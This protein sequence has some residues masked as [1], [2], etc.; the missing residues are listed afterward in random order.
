MEELVAAVQEGD[1]ALLH[2]LIALASP[3]LLDSDHCSLL[4]WAAINNRI[5]IA[6]LLIDRGAE[7]LPGGILYET[8][9][10]WALRKKYYAM[11]HL[12]VHRLRPELSHK[13]RDGLDALHLACRLEDINAVFLLLHWGANPDTQDPDGDTPLLH[14]LRDPNPT[15]LV[16]EMIRVLLSFQANSLAQ[17]RDGNSPL[18][19]LAQLHQRLDFS[20]ATMIL[21]AA[22]RNA[23]NITNRAGQSAYTVCISIKHTNA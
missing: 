14:L 1:L 10:Q 6:N 2:N 23:L 8:P 7:L 17:D 4:H 13:S 3:N 5:A 19:L 15:P 22:P 9:L 18:H 11:M 12:L 21:Q 16:I 20:L